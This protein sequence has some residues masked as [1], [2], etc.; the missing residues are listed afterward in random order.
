MLTHLA[1]VVD[2]MLASAHTHFG[3]RSHCQYSAVLMCVFVRTFTQ[4]TF[5]TFVMAELATHPFIAE[6]AE[7]RKQRALNPVPAPTI[8]A[9]PRIPFRSLQH[10]CCDHQ[11]RYDDDD[12]R[13]VSSSGRNGQRRAAA[14]TTISTARHRSDRMAT[15]TRAPT[16]TPITTTIMVITPTIILKSAK[17]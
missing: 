5:E 12:S 8:T 16:R 14:A 6:T 10:H 4:D 13:C 9:T 3:L 11:H 2:D 17:Q 15:I 7:E 1:L